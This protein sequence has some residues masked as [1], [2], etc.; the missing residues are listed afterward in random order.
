MRK[1]KILS[2]LDIFISRFV[3]TAMTTLNKIYVYYAT[4]SESRYVLW[5]IFDYNSMRKLKISIVLRYISLVIYQDIYQLCIKISIVISISRLVP[6]AMK[7]LNTTR[8]IYANLCN[9]RWNATVLH[10]CTNQTW[11]VLVLV[12]GNRWKAPWQKPP[13]K[14]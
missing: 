9:D 6:A 14:S 1:L 2:S 12:R 4:Y 10:H 5:N 3:P 8:T 11:C 13:V 7:T